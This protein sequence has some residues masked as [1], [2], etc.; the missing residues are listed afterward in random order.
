MA[1]ERENI[2]FQEKFASFLEQTNVLAIEL[3]E[4]EA[5]RLRKEMAPVNE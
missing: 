5:E 4:S 3:Q 2:R 1:T